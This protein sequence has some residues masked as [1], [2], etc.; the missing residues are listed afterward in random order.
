[1]NLFLQIALICGCLVSNRTWSEPQPTHS[2][3]LIVNYG[4]QSVIDATAKWRDY[5]LDGYYGG[6]SAI[7]PAHLGQIAWIKVAGRDWIGPLLVV[8]AVAK[9]DAYGSIYEREEI[10]EVPRWLA[11]QLGFTHGA[12]GQI[13]FGLCPPLYEFSMARPYAPELHWDYD[14]SEPHLDFWPYPEQQRPVRDCTRDEM[15]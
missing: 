11:A 9:R 7:S 13:Y 2:Q 15:E 1:M 6:I 10:A 12:W 14:N 3:G 5:E 4:G 8:D